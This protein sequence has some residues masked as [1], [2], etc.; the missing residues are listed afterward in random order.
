MFSRQCTNY[1]NSLILILLGI[2]IGY[3]I[4]YLTYW[5][6]PYQFAG[7][8][9]PDV[10]K[11][12][13]RLP[14]TMQDTSKYIIPNIVHYIWF[15]NLSEGKEFNFFNYL[16]ILSVCKIQQPEEI[17]FHCDIIPTDRWWHKAWHDFPITVRHISPRTEIFGSQIKYKEHTVDIARLEILLEHGGIY[18]DSNVIIARPLDP[19]RR[20]PAVISHEKTQK[21]N[22]G[23]VLAAQNSSFL[24]LWYDAYKTDFQPNSFAYNTGEKPYQIY[25]K[26]KDLLHLENESLSLALSL[27][28]QDMMENV[29]DWSLF[30]TLHVNEFGKDFTP[31]NIKHKQSTVCEILRYICYDSK[32]PLL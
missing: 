30:F 19:L 14:R 8:F 2:F 1:K 17:I 10:C 18:L 25:M 9:P 32:E 27:T 7:F 12:T 6:S 22:A 20:Y 15:S 4:H 29:V 5:R 23:T 26:H 31:E 11:K 24:R 16:S 3:G 28:L 13:S 21:F